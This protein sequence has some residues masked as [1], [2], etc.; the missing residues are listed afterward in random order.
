MPLFVESHKQDLRGAFPVELVFFL[1]H[2][3]GLFIG[4]VLDRLV[5]HL[6]HP[7]LLRFFHLFKLH[8]RGRNAAQNVR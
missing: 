4:L 7:A 1:Q 8:C 5:H 2:L 3:M 6:R